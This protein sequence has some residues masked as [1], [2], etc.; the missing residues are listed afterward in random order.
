MKQIS[1]RH[2][3]HSTNT[4]KLQKYT[5]IKE[6]LTRIWQ[7]NAVNMVPLALSTT[8]IIPQKTTD[9]LK[10]FNFRPA[11]ICCKAESSNT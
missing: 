1:N 8:G 7:L 3:L 9:S 5:G 10:L 6:M 11:V 4:E 2:G